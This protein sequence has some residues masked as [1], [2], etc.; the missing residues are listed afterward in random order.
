MGKTATGY[1]VFIAALGMMCGLLAADI[2]NLEQWA[3]MTTPKFVGSV[4][5]HLAAVIAAFIGGRI[6]P[7]Y[8]NGKLTRST[9]LKNDVS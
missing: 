3:Y 8:R 1:T 5:T 2:Q 7:E 9:D 4:F 6:V